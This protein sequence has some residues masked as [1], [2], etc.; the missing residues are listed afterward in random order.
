MNL[1]LS[2]LVF[3]KAPRFKV[4][5]I[6]E[7]FSISGLE[8]LNY[9]VTID[10]V[11][12]SGYDNG[13]GVSIKSGSAVFVFNPRKYDKDNP[14]PTQY[15]EIRNK[16]ELD[17]S[18]MD[19]IVKIVNNGKVELPSLPNSNTF[20]SYTVYSPYKLYG[21][22]KWIKVEDIPVRIDV[23][24][25]I[26]YAI[27]PNDKDY[28]GWKLEA[29][30]QSYGSYLDGVRV[31]YSNLDDIPDFN[32]N[33]PVT[34]KGIAKALA[35]KIDN[36]TFK[37][38]NNESIIGE[39]N[40]EIK[41]TNIVNNSSNGISSMAG[42]QSPIPIISFDNDVT[43]IYEKQQVK[44]II[45]NYSLLE[46]YYIEVP[47]FMNHTKIFD[48]G[49][50]F[51]AGTTNEDIEGY[52]KV[53]SYSI[54]NATSWSDFAELKIMI[55]ALD[56]VEGHSII[57]NGSNRSRIK[58]YNSPNVEFY[59]SKGHYAGITNGIVDINQQE[60]G[61]LKSDESK[62]WISGYLGSELPFDIVTNK[63][64]IKKGT[65]VSTKYSILE[66]SILETD[67]LIAHFPLI[68]DLKST[69]DLYEFKS[70]KNQ[71]EFKDDMLQF[72]DS[73]KLIVDN[74]PFQ[75]I[76]N[77]N[78][79]IS[80]W[81]TVKVRPGTYPIS[82]RIGTNNICFRIQ[83]HNTKN[84]FWSRN[85]NQSFKSRTFH[86][87]NYPLNQLVDEIPFHISMYKVEN[88]WDYLVIS[89]PYNYKYGVISRSGGN[90]WHY[91]K[92]N[93][94]NQ[95]KNLFIE[96][97]GKT[98][99]TGVRISNLRIYE[100]I[101]DNYWRRPVQERHNR[102]EMILS[103]K[104]EGHTPTYSVINHELGSGIEKAVLFRQN[105][106]IL[107]EGIE[108]DKYPSEDFVKKLDSNLL[109]GARF[110]YNLGGT[111]LDTERIKIEIKDDFRFV[112]QIKLNTVE[113]KQIN[114]KN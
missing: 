90:F 59:S 60:L 32:S 15:F 106:K 101:S 87:G 79:Y 77:K 91:Y 64:I 108:L 57:M 68:N 13:N 35:S 96:H 73:D 47:E 99:F 93:T 28:E 89:A 55:K 21:A 12:A 80:F 53:K 41:T 20:S 84:Y 22:D 54:P 26:P 7:L 100:K 81:V 112:S 75:K 45:E 18:E 16:D 30:Y 61:I 67:D 86:T 105:P 76:G 104:S 29:T 31:D 74:F 42:F 3:A 111:K 8:E 11:N 56:I 48:D 62:L 66:N 33:N 23:I 44:V 63:G 38:I 37:T 95:A 5:N 50:F 27:F 110:T 70:D 88:K 14:D 51:V 85:G 9:E 107:V 1:D 4:N 109:S 78:Y 49:T 98:A 103:L 71:Y 46:H 102:Q 113:E 52:V 10:V 34:S 24:D 39:G 2:G 94:K 43:E 19:T 82:L 83:N 36:L 69:N 17:V 92:Y 6:Q 58:N 40:I 97:N 72:K 25:D 114:E 65:P